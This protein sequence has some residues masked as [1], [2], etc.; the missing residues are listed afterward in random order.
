ML[1]DQ[2]KTFGQVKA[3]LSRARLCGPRLDDV[4]TRQF[5]EQ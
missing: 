3:D 5:V 4:R 1:S 2:P